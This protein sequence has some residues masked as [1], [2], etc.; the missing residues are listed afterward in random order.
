[1]CG[2]QLQPGG[3]HGGSLTAVA[4]DPDCVRAVGVQ[5]LHQEA[6][7][8]DLHILVLDHVIAH[9]IGAH[10]GDL[11]RSLG[12]GDRETERTHQNTQRNRENTSEHTEKQR[13]HI[14]THRETEKTHQN[15]LRNRENTSEHTEK[16][17]EHIRTHREKKIPYTN[18]CIWNLKKKIKKKL[19]LKDLG[20][21]QE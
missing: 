10:A 2:V 6:G 13:E 7:R 15:T 18:A 12:L 16:Q 20:T 5:A 4:G 17:R 8:G 19:V 9:V 3:P 11:P 14:R 21:G 1:M